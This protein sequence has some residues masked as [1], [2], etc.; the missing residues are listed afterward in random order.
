MKKLLTILSVIML[1]SAVPIGAFAWSH[2]ILRDSKTNNWSATTNNVTFTDDYNCYVDIDLTDSNSDFYFHFYIG[3]YKNYCISPT[4]N[5]IE[6]GNEW[7]D[8][9]A[10]YSAWENNNTETWNKCKISHSTDNYNTYRIYLRNT[11]TDSN[12]WGT[13]G[14]WQV[15]VEGITE[16]V[17]VTIS[18]NGGSF[19]TSS[20]EV[21][22]T[23]SNGKD[24]H[25]TTD[26]STP[27][28]DQQL[29]R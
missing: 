4:S 23:S 18:P 27:T 15:K 19:I 26:G 24:V 28:K 11:D 29:A 25:Y 8:L 10:W 17:R 22:L 14:S 2:I 9:G 3:D 12:N 6:V 1:L 7:V 13:S 16:K 20:E 21:T 5:G